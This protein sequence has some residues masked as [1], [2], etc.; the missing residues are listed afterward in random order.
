MN[1]DFYFYRQEADSY[2]FIRVPY[3]LVQDYKEIDPAA[4]LLYGVLLSRMALSR[5]N[6]WMD[7]SDRVFIFYP[8]EEI[9]KTL[10]CKRDKAMKLLR[11]LEQADLIARTHQGVGRADRIYVKKFIRVEKTDP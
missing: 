8:I 9:C 3:A 6:K 7:G 11:Q 5:K 10:C 4:K 2:S 1:Q